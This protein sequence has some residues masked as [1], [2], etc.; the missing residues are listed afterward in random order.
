MVALIIGMSQDF[1]FIASVS[2]G[3]TLLWPR[4]QMVRAL[5]I[6]GVGTLCMEVGKIFLETLELLAAGAR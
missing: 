3:G 5:D 2:G 6:N 1:C 4:D